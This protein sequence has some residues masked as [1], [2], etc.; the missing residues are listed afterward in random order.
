M[1]CGWGEVWGPRGREGDERRS[2]FEW[3]GETVEGG[4]GV[5]ADWPQHFRRM[6]AKRRGGWTESSRRTSTKLPVSPSAALLLL[7]LLLLLTPSLHPFI[8]PP[9]LLPPSQ[10]PTPLL[11]SAAPVTELRR[12]PQLGTNCVFHSGAARWWKRLWE[13][14][15]AASQL[16]HRRIFKI[17]KIGWKKM[18]ETKT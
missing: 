17:P 18:E 15:T 2:E 16:Y 10:P 13:E 6:S 8:H 4:G 9:S 3:Q 12:R 14:V 5:T 1:A 7:P 11:P